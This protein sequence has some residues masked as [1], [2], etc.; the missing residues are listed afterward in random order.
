MTTRKA[1]GKKLRFDVFKRDLFTCQYC[2]AAPP[3]VVLEV[4]H[5]HPVAEGGKDHADNLLTAC[6][7]CNRGKGAIPLTVI[8]KSLSEQAAEIKEREEQ[9]AGYRDVMQLRLDRIEAD[10]WRVADTLENDASTNGM[11]REWLQSVKNF[12]ARLPLHSVVDAA[13]IA[14]A[15]K[16]WSKAA[17]FRYFCG[18]C[19]NR[20][21]EL[22]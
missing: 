18:I 13:E 22:Q 11:R 8:P 7:D 20:I 2:G 1:L 14:R 4:D 15:A 6:F 9:L 19:W 3:A 5:I 17:R 16:P 10:M 21:R 12:N